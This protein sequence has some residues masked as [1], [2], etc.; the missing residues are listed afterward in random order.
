VSDLISLPKLNF[1]TLHYSSVGL[2]TGCGLDLQGSIPGMTSRES[3][4][5]PMAIQPLIQLVP[6]GR[7]YM[8]IKQPGREAD[9]SPSSAEVSNGGAVSPQGVLHGIVLN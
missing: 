6:G 4:P 7:I 1:F 5:P 2:A 9:H 3:R 8:G